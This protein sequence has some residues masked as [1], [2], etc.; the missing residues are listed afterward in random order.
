MIFFLLD[1]FYQCNY[2]I[3][4]SK[5]KITSTRAFTAKSDF[6]PTIMLEKQGYKEEIELPK[7]DHFLNMISYLEQVPELW[8]LND[9][10]IECDSRQIAIMIINICR[11]FLLVNCPLDKPLIEREGAYDQ[12]KFDIEA[13]VKLV[14]QGLTT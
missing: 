6:N 4:G 11:G 7:D 2:E 5:G 8:K 13:A 12:V 3:W 9:F 1:N 14:L 10:F